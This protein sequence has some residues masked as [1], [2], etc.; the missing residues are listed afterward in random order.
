MISSSFSTI[1]VTAL[2]TIA[3]INLVNAQQKIGI[4]LC[5]CGPKTYEFTL[6]FSLSCPPED[7]SLGKAVVG[8]ACQ[9]STFGDPNVVDMIPVAV[10]SITV[11]ELGQDF[12]VLVQEHI[13]K[14]FKDGD[15]FQYTSIA[16]EDD[17]INDPINIPKGIQMFIPGVNRNDEQILIVYSIEFSNNCETFPVLSEGQYIGWTRFVSKYNFFD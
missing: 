8:T 5:A 16:A 10:Q 15:T 13:E 2:A 12:Q 1:L 11:Y 14:D 3:G 7:V 17:E 9:V 4:D 6:D